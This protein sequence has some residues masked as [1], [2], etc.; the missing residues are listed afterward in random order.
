MT[1]EYA[2]NSAYVQ[3]MEE[4][5][6]QYPSI[7]AD[8]YEPS[9]LKDKVFLGFPENSWDMLCE[10]AQLQLAGVVSG[11]GLGLLPES[12]A[13]VMAAIVCEGEFATSHEVFTIVPATNVRWIVLGKP[14]LFAVD[15][16]GNYSRLIKGEKLKSAGKNTIARLY[17]AAITGDKLVADEDGEPQ[18]FTLNL[19]STKTKLIGKPTD[20]PGSGTLSALNNGLQKHYKTKGWLGGLVSVE[21]N[22]VTHKFDYTDGGAAKSSI[23]VMFTLGEGAKIIPEDC[24]K[25][26]FDRIDD[27]LKATMKD[28]FGVSSSVASQAQPVEDDENEAY[29]Y[30]AEGNPVVQVAF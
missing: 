28:P 27:D 13:A 26:I 19:K 21:I 17:L 9:K 25:A 23:G 30:D 3:E 5:G 15:K 20:K 12:L 11:Q 14:G 18:I 16:E 29:E 22:A 6:A 8:N 2:L 7:M 1:T 10:S 4:G 24:Q